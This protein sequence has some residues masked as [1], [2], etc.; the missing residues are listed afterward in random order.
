MQISITNETDTLQTVVLGIANS[1]GAAPTPE[2][3]YDPKSLEHIKNH[4][5]PKEEDMVREM[6][7][8][9]QVLQKHGVEVLRPELIT[10][11]NQIFA[12][13]IGFVIEDFFIKANIL[14][15]REKELQ[16]I[17]YIIKQ[18]PQNQV[19][20]PPKE[21]HVEGGDVIPHNDFIFVGTYYGAD[22]KD[23]ITARTHPKAVDF[24]QELFPQKTVIGLDL[25][26]SVTDPYYNALHLDC[27]FQPVG[28][29]KAIIFK[30]GFKKESDYQ[31]IKEIFGEENLFEITREE[32]YQMNSNIFSISPKVVVCE[33]HFH[34]LRKWLTGQGIEVETVPY[35]E[36]SKQEGLLRCSTLPLLRKKIA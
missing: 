16:A 9:A 17:E 5:Y 6:S 28:E 33:E 30:G 23:I 26:K 22:Y 32:M 2:Q 31:Y 20:T 8:F 11:Y 1:N 25:V 12:R 18:I 13:D 3:A 14:P 29:N 7:A 24:L 34:R 15:D 36:I 27:C 10:D 19:I 21:I 4:T 35:A